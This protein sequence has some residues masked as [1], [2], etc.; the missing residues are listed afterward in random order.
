METRLFESERESNLAGL[1]LRFE[2]ERIKKENEARSFKA[3]EDIKRQKIFLYSLIIISL[4]LSGLGSV[5]FISYKRK[6]KDNNLLKIQKEQIE[7]K[8]I[9]I[10][11][12]IKEITHQKNEIEKISK[13]LH[14][15]DELKLKFF[16]NISHEFR[17]P[18][19]L[20]ITPLA[21]LIKNNGGD[22][23]VSCI[24]LYTVMPASCKI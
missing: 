2:F 14:E 20:I 21:K 17:T 4:L 23:Q 1:E 3:E 8:N 24:L 19:T 13:Q 11:N 10:E 16:T 15:A 5:I 9:D 22:E 7:Q 18:L 12:K 6:K